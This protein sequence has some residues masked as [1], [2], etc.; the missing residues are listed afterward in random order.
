MPYT[1]IYQNSYIVAAI[2]FVVLCIVFY[3]LEIGYNVEIKDGKVIK[4]FS[5]KYPLAIALIVW[6]IW[7]FYLYPPTSLKENNTKIDKP[8][9]I[10]PNTTTSSSSFSFMYDKN[11]PQKIDMVNWN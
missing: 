9:K 1:H 11:I 4:N 2:V 3:F 5:W 10:A 8:R 6:I 7:Y